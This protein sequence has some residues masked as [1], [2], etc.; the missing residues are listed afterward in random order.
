MLLRARLHR[1]AK[2]AA[3]RDNRLVGEVRRATLNI[4]KHES[5]K[6]DAEE[7]LE[8]CNAALSDASDASDDIVIAAAGAESSLPRSEQDKN[9]PSGES[10]LKS[11]STSVHFFWF[12]MS[13]I[14]CVRYRPTQPSACRH[15]TCAHGIPYWLNLRLI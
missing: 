14:Y 4:A 12:A 8:K 2:A 6:A 9:M 1:A 7:L 5:Q 11:E 15:C 13:T 10:M 3:Q